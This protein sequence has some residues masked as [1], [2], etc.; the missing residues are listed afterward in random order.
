MV[1]LLWALSACPSSTGTTTV[2][3]SCEDGRIL[4]SAGGQR[5]C[6]APPAYQ[7]EILTCGTATAGVLSS[8]GK[9]LS[10][11]SADYGLGQA[12]SSTAATSCAE[13]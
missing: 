3:V 12:L 2:P 9:T 7:A 11:G 6:G 5:H 4:I 10:C 8:D 1:P 13:R